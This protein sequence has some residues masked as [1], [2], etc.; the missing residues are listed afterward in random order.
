M[1]VVKQQRTPALTPEL[2]TKIFAHLEELPDFLDWDDEEQE[3]NQAKVHQLK[4]VCKQFRDVDASHSG[5][6]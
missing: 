3:P 5:L 4:L 6:V 2:W 1:G